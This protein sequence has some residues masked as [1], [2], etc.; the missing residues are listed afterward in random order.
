MK[1]TI[2]SALLGLLSIAHC[3]R[4]QK[5]TN[6]FSNAD[7]YT[8]IGAMA[9]IPSGQFR[10]TDLK[11]GG[12]AGTGWGLYFDS[13]TVLKSGL[14]FVSHSTYSW[15]PLNDAALNTSFTRELGKKTMISGGRHMPFLT[16]LGL[17]YEAHPKKFI[18]L[19]LS[20]QAGLMYNSFKNF[21]I[22]VYDT[23]NTTVLFNDNLKY[24]SQFSF[25]Y[26]IG[27]QVGFRLIKDLLDFQL[28]ADY[29]ASK[30]SSTLRGSELPAIRTSQHIQLINVG[31]GI[32][33]HTK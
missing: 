2:S 3:A 6:P 10:S 16:T 27:A 28:I 11:N 26:V 5:F 1:Y 4:A 13:K 31:A 20:A 33:V 29:S 24:D 21:D 32:V 23:D 19:G 17:G 30:F 7:K 18:T 8:S 25:A 9:S 22:T 14:Y 15:V 12:Y